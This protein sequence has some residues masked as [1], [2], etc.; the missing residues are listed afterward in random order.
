MNELLKNLETLRID[1]SLECAY[2]DPTGALEREYNRA[3]EMLDEC[4]EYAKDYLNV[5][6]VERT[7]RTSW[8]QD[9]KMIVVAKDK[10]CAERTA[11][12]RSE[13]FKKATLEVTEIDLTKEAVISVENTGA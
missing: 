4:I 1:V 7:D 6:C 9:Y 5:Y 2:C 3:N 13:D 12:L 11:R 10:L 8:C